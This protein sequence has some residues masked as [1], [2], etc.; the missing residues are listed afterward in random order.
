[1]TERA[2]QLMLGKLNQL[3]SDIA[4]Q[5]AILNQS[6]MNGWQGI[7]PLNEQ[8]ERKQENVPDWLKKKN[9]YNS[10]MQRDY[11]FESLENELIGYSNKDPNFAEQKEAAE[12]RIKD[13]CCRQ[14]GETVWQISDP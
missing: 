11:D 10:F 2:I 8:K 5:I 9:N 6:I 4:T 14:R 7:F 13:I 3:S 1:M 12:K